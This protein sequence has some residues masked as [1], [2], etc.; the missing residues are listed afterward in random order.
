MPITASIIAGGI[1]AGKGIQS[2]IRA[3]RAKKEIEGLQKGLKDPRF[4]MPKEMMQ[5]YDAAKAMPVSRN[6]PGYGAMQNL[7][8]VQ[9]ASALGDISKYG[10]GLDA[11]AALTNLG[12]QGMAQQQQIGIEN[13]QNYQS[14]LENRRAN[15]AN[16]ASQ[17][18]EYRQMEYEQN[19]L[20]PFLRTSAA[21]S[22]LRQKRYQE[23]NLAF[24]AFANVARAGG[25]M[26]GGIGGKTTTTTGNTGEFGETGID[27]IEP[28]LYG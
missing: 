4:E 21:I 20:N 16:M 25:G 27:T 24:D 15:M 18:G 3:N 19:V 5:A 1:A 6:M 13:A 7:M 9:Q 2:L 11:V 28:M 26:M 10:T 17:L 8:G 14:Q 22:A 12:T 23:S